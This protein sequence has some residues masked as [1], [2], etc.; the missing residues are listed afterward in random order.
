MKASRFSTRWVGKADASGF[1]A[2]LWPDPGALSTKVIIGSQ[3]RSVASG[4][5]PVPAFK[6]SFSNLGLAGEPEQAYRTG[7]G[8]PAPVAAEPGLRAAARGGWQLLG[9]A[10]SSVSKH[11][12]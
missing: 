11:V 7:V 2:G 3:G 10:S 5:F 4:P 1:A 6:A 8:Q 9:V 12:F